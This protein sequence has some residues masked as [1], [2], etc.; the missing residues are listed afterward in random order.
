ML[1]SS[2]TNT[3]IHPR[4]YHSSQSFFLSREI[5]LK[6]NSCMCRSRNI[7]VINR[8]LGRST[9]SLRSLNIAWCCSVTKSCATLLWLHG[10]Y[11]SP[12][13][14]VRGIF[15]ARTLE[16]V[17]ISFSRGS[18]WLRDQIW[19]ADSL[20]LNHHFAHQF[21]L[22]K[23][24]IVFLLTLSVAVTLMTPIFRLQ[25]WCNQNWTA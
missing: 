15:Q 24:G 19:Q 23:W 10:L 5:W 8:E 11:S 13:S 20:P 21:Q 9:C 14:S 25:F 2:V 4:D 18:S 16:W 1:K 7:F 6:K 3:Q 17:A 22:I 12:G